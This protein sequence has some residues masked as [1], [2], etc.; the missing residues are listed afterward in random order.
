MLLP[1]ELARG[2][3]GFHSAA[4]L[5]PALNALAD[6][7]IVQ[8][9][10]IHGMQ[11]SGEDEMASRRWTSNPRLWKQAQRKRSASR[12]RAEWQPIL[13]GARTCIAL[14]LRVREATRCLEFCLSSACRCAS[15]P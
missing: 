5:L 7:L 8:R 11:V 6:I 15:N 1:R 3:L 10:F 4:D 9:A 12:S 2:E 14:G 13:R